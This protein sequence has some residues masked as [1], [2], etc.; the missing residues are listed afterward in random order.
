M[1]PEGLFGKFKFR[2]AA[3]QSAAAVPDGVAVKCAQC[4]QIIFAKDFERSLKVCSHCGFHHRLTA[5]E[6]IQYT[7]DEGS[8]QPLFETLR[9]GDPLHFPDYPAKLD[10]AI[11]A[12]GFNDSFQTGLASVLGVPLVLGVA[13]FHFM[14]GSMGSVHGEKIA[15]AMEVGI[16]RNLPVVI[17]TATGG[18]ARMH[19]GIL[20]LMQM[21]KTTAAA[22]RL[23]QARLP[24]LVVMTDMTM[25]GVLASY[26]SVG[27]IHL[28]EPAATI[29]FAGARVVAQATVQKPPADYQT[30]EWQLAH[31]HLDQVVARRDL[32]QTLA[33]QLTLLG[34]GPSESVIAPEP[35]LNGFAKPEAVHG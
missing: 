34:F 25:A 13:D 19:E 17:F 1:P 12:T 20:S 28:A 6:R 22:A 10:K 21:A 14:A 3:A 29:G 23:S 27:D 35:S 16:Q 8:W 9:S 30:A 26:A 15:R 5:A 24:Y 18:G 33:T 2:S 32:P 7:S 4:G 11:K 31:G